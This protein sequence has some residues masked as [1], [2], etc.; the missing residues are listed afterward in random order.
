MLFTLSSVS[1]R[2]CKGKAVWGDKQKLCRILTEVMATPAAICDK[3]AMKRCGRVAKAS[4]S[5]R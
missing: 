1:F 4:A 5:A 2:R 3:S